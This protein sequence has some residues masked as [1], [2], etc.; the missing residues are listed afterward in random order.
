MSLSL[1][2]HHEYNKIL[3]IEDDPIIALD[4]SLV[5]EEMGCHVVGIAKN[6]NDALDVMTHTPANILLCDI[7]L[8]TKESGID[9][10]KRIYV[11]HT[12]SVI[13]LSASADIQTVKVAVDTNP[14]GYLV[15][16]YRYAELFALVSLALRQSKL[17]YHGQTPQVLELGGG[18]HF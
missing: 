8:Q 16:P 17:S 9:I 2:P 4:L 11:D 12:P 18:Y 1:I 10:V 14:C 5:V 13:Y 7:T 6:Y 3:I 15:K